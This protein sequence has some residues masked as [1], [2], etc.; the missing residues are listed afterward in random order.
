VLSG[1]RTCSSRSRAAS[2]SARCAAGLSFLG[3]EVGAGAGVVSSEGR[4]GEEEEAGKYRGGGDEDDE[5]CGAADV[6]CCWRE[7]FE[8]EGG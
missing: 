1:C 6:W 4:W 3:D 2:I 8:S 7:E 5:G